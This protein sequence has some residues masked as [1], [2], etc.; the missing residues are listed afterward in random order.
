[1]LELIFN[2]PASGVVATVVLFDIQVFNIFVE[3][4]LSSSP[5]AIF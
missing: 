2:L 1:M 4:H 3:S 5:A